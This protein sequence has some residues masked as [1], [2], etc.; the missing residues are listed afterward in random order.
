MHR[1]TN[2]RRRSR[3]FNQ[4]ARLLTREAR[5]RPECAGL[6]PGLTAGAWDSAA[7]VADRL[8]ADCLMRGSHAALRGRVL[9][10]AH[11]E[12]RGGAARGGERVGMRPQRARA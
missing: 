8:L 7:V 6:Y 3:G 2:G 9:L 12:F 11:F 10:D 4:P 5:L 1:T